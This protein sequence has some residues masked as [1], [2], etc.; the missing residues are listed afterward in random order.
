MACA[1]VPAAAEAAAWLLR[2]GGNAFDAAI[3]G[4]A[5][6]PSGASPE[7][8]TA[9]GLAAIPDS[10]IH[11]ATVPG[12]VHAWQTLHDRLGRASFAEC[13]APAIALAE[14]GYPVSEIV[15]HDWQL[16]LAIG[17]LQNDEALRAF[18]LDGE[19]PAAGSVFRTP[20]L[21]A[22]LREIAEGGAAAFY[23]GRVS[24]A[25]VA[26]SEALGGGF[27]AAGPTDRASRRCWPSARL[28][29][30]PPR[31]RARPWPGTSASRP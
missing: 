2:S 10:G 23:E 5:A 1:S 22:T 30:G 11:S 25:I 17:R 16:V 19:A 15:A 8:I 21:A 4:A 13:L 27:S 26:T 6:P 12:A 20:A 31:P 14:D 24:E 7:A 3:A 29:T 28:P 9:A 18:S